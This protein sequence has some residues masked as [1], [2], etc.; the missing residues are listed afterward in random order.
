MKVPEG[1]LLLRVHVRDEEEDGVSKP[2]RPMLL[3]FDYNLF[4]KFRQ[5]Q[6]PLYPNIGSHIL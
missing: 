4:M 5:K 1:R 3:L 6:A 2:A